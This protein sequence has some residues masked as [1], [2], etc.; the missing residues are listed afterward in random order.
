MH[1]ARCKFELCGFEEAQCEMHSNTPS[2]QDLIASLMSLLHFKN[3]EGP[4]V[5]RSTLP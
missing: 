3:A 4:G 5:S 1:P 2:G